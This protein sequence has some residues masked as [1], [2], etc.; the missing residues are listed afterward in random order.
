MKRKPKPPKQNVALVSTPWPLYSRP[1]I[2]LGTL[3]SYLQ[4]QS[5]N[6][7][8]EAHHVYLN[9]AERLGYQLYQEIA[10][11]TWIAE[12]IYAVLLFPE[13]FQQIEGL[14]KREAGEKLVKTGLKNIVT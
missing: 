6:V 11:R 5:A 8:V 14:F 12:S 1:S 2:Q 10:E 7:T 13:R 9:V 3:K 4:S